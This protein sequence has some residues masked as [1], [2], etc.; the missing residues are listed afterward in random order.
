MK[1]IFPFPRALRA[2]ALIFLAVIASKVAANPT[3]MTVVS[4][5]ATAQ[6]LGSQLNVAVS[7]LAI[8]NWSSFNI[9]AGETTSFLQPSANS[10][11]FNEIGDANPSQIFGNVNGNGTVILANANGF[12]FGPNSMIK[13]GGSFIATTAALAP[14]FGSGGAWQFTGMPPTASIINYGRIEVGPGRSLFLIAE[15]IENNGSLNAPGGNVDLVA[16]QNI[17]VSD[18]PDGRGLSATVQLPSGSVNN[19]GQITADA[20]TIALQAKV[21]NQDGL[22]Q[23][24]SIQ[25]QDGQIELLA[26]DQLNLGA[27]SQ[28][29][30]NG[31]DSPGGSAGGTVTVKSGNEFS[32]NPG[33]QISVTGGSQGGNGGSVE[34]SAPS[35]SAINT[36]ISGQAQAGWTGGTLLLDPDYIVLNTSGSGTVNVNGESGSLQAGDD[37][38]DTLYLDVGTSLDSFADSAFIGL[39]QITLQANYNITLASG[40]TWNLSS[41]T[42]QTEGQLTLQAGGNIIFQTGATIIDANQWSLELQAGYDFEDNIV[43]PNTGN[44]Y[45]NGGAGLAGK[46]TI[47]LANGSV[48]LY[49]GDSI[50]VGSGSV[51]TTGSGSIFA[52]AISGDINTG[53]YNGGTS[54][55]GPASSDYQFRSGGTIPN[56]VLGGI[57]TGAAGGTGGNVTLIAGDDVISTPTYS[58]TQ[59]QWP[60]ASGAY[61]SG[62]VTVIAGNEIVGNYNLANGTGTI[63]AGVPVSASQ[64]AILQDPQANST[65][66][67]DTLTTLE[68]S[69]TTAINPEGNVGMISG[70]AEPV[71][72]SLIDGSWNVWAANDIYLQEVNNPNGT[73]NQLQNFRF[74]YA[75]DAAVNLWAG[76]A[77][78]LVAASAGLA[79][80]S[81][82]NASMPPIYAPNLSLNAGAGGITLDASIILYPSSD[83]EGSLQIVTRDGGNLVG[84]TGSSSST[85]T[86]ITMS[87]SGSTSWSTFATSHAS[88]PL[89][90]DNPDP[91]TVDISGSIENFGLTVPTYAQINVVGNTYNFGF[92]GQNLSPLQTTYIN[93]G[94]KAKTTMEK[95]GLLDSATDGGLVVGGNITFRGDLTSE[96]LAGAILS[97]VIGQIT[98]VDPALAGVLGYDPAS[99]D[100]SFAGT[101]S[102]A[103]EQTLLNPVDSSGNAIFTGAQLTAWQTAITQLYNASQ[104]AGVSTTEESAGVISSS[105]SSEVAE[106]ISD[107]EITSD[108][109]SLAGEFSYDAA[110]GQ[111]SFVGQMSYPTEQS[112]LDPLD[113]NNNPILSGSQL[114]A[115]QATITQL[116]NDSLSASLGANGL[117]ISGPG[118][119]NINADTIDLGVSSGILVNAPDAQLANISPIGADI[120]IKTTGDLEMTTTAIANES[121]MGNITLNV[122]GQLDVGGELSA[123]GTPG[124]ALGIFTTGEG[125]ISVTANNDVNVDGSRIAAYD[126]GNISVESLN[127]DVNAGTGGEGYVALNAVELDPTSGDLEIIPAQIPGSGILATTVPYGN[128]PLGNITV[129]APNGDINANLGG[130]IQIAFNGNQNNDDFISLTASGDINASGSGIIGSNIKLKAGGDITGV[131]IGSQSV[132]IDSAQNVDVTAVSGGNV[133]INAGGD[134]SGTI[135]SGGGLDVS[136][137]DINA[138]LISESVSASGDASG[139]SMGIPQSNVSSVTTQTADNATEAAAKTDNTDDDDQK[140]KHAQTTLA[141]KTSRVTVTLPRQN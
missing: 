16:G 120:C 90:L 108:N 4:G 40:T 62:N 2:A 12:Y 45:L 128:A 122:G 78:D 63:L 23:A 26:S 39:S 93:V 138:S 21:V 89:Y 75:A 135:V 84:A 105:I 110:S 98:T 18:S 60:G 58:L 14:D 50:L 22:I 37:P 101:M 38:G 116:Y 114:T 82:G 132:N 119:F 53:T 70:T 111:V 91:V 139:A 29:S 97:D 124:E 11:V 83:G 10:I 67:N 104:N 72:L 131:V 51:F 46:G 74:N 126:G 7:Q 33:S 35:I 65:A 34:I 79:R 68:S 134:V 54:I 117:I 141:Q 103:T 28:I 56:A 27:D 88:T 69:V 94:Q 87:D 41:S 17:L 8:L 133:D 76:D 125:N 55:G 80:V 92:L 15:N 61:G 85:L 113:V 31:D 137:S 20:G 19:A 66:Y 30:A 121:Y 129:T 96:A 136:G 1:N 95:L 44:I 71:T 140:K 102:V 73:F 25:D 57:S 13:V 127:G 5:G 123:F 32:D 24:D 106:I 48:D 52:D 100:I 130:I 109:P 86:G 42:G 36:K 99:G 77:I 6:Q 81:R 59:G 118:H 43:Q 47:A 49:A 107:T 115:W 112:L 64:A 3:G 9:A